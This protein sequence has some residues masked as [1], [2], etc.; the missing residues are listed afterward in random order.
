MIP[1]LPGD[2]GYEVT[3]VQNFTDIDDKIIERANEEGVDSAAV[4]ERE[5]RRAISAIARRR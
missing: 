5:H 4:A 2:L 1:P 3:Y